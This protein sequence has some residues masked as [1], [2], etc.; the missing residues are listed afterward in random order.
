MVKFVKIYYYNLNKNS[1]IP[2]TRALLNK[3]FKKPKKML[4]YAYI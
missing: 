3:A 1:K 4:K 2:Q